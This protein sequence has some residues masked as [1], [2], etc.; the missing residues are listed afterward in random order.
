[1][2]F[3]K[4]CSRLLLAVLSSPLVALAAPAY[5]V[6]FAPA[7]FTIN[8][9]TASQLNNQGQV[10]GNASGVPAIWQGTQVTR[11]MALAGHHAYGINNRGDIVGSSTGFP[12]VYT[13]AGIRYI[14]IEQPLE[15]IQPGRRHQW[16]RPGDRLR[17]RAGGRIGAG[18]FEFL[19]RDRAR[20]HLGRR[21]ELRLQLE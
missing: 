21:L 7:G 16:R 13:R 2:I 1:M 18:F 4:Y 12:F 11:I 14:P 15:R 10:I 19:A 20:W 5:Q 9:F 17:P 3:R 6:A 8:D